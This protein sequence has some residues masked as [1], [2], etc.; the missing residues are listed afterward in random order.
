MTFKLFANTVRHNFVPVNFCSH[1]W[2]L[3]SQRL[4]GGVG[5]RL[6]VLRDCRLII[7]LRLLD[8]PY[9]ILRRLFLVRDWQALLHFFATDQLYIPVLVV[10]YLYFEATSQLGVSRIWGKTYGPYR[11]PAAVPKV[12]RLK[13]MI[14]YA[15]R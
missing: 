10:M 9:Q 15:R 8:K 11:T 14:L 5:H 13:L 4:K 1:Y 6:I 3:P 2:Q 12:F 7:V